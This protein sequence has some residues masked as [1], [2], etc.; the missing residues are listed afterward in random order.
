MLFRSAID[1][2]GTL[3]CW[4]YAA[5]VSRGYLGDGT[6]NG[7]S[8]P[9]QIGTDTDWSSVSAGTNHTC[10]IKT[11]GS[12][13]CWGSNYSG[14]IGIGSVDEVFGLGQDTPVQVGTDSDWRSVS[15]GS[16]NTCA[17][18]T[19]NDLYCWG[20]NTNGQIGDGTQVLRSSQIGRAHV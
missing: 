3:W 14:Q 1:V 11:D 17:V 10:A 4:G 18:K 2:D 13:Y 20:I 9:I 7:S 12:L 15:A 6:T 5:G 19:N 16:L 8:V